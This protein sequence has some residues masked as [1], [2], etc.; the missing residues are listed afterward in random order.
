VGFV[1]GTAVAKDGKQ[2]PRSHK[3]FNVGRFT[4]SKH[5]TFHITPHHRPPVNESH[6]FVFISRPYVT[7]DNTCLFIMATTPQIVADSSDAE[8]GP[9][10]AQPRPQAR[11]E[12]SN[13]AEYDRSDEAT[14]RKFFSQ[15]WELG[16]ALAKLPAADR[17]L[18]QCDRL[19]SVDVD[20][21]KLPNTTDNDASVDPY[22]IR[23]GFREKWTREAP[24]PRCNSMGF[25]DDTADWVTWDSYSLYTTP[26]TPGFVARSRRFE[27]GC[28]ETWKLISSQLLLYR[29][30]AVFGMPPSNDDVHIE[31][32]YKSIWS[33]TLYWKPG[34]DQEHGRKVW[35]DISDCK[36]TFMLNFCGP[37][38]ASR[39]ALDLFAWLVSDNVPHPCDGVLA[40]NIA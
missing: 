33:Y 31:G 26:D 3:V 34:W 16:G 2:R 7:G 24:P 6:P 20:V 13:L 32:M 11:V 19:D 15:L 9:E 8:S 17:R 5:P 27:D 38:E 37:E 12:I 25:L 4:S 21:D 1:I 35:F 10:T 29:L 14:R 22:A 28:V 36:G 23:D 18:P 40:G 30:I 39:S